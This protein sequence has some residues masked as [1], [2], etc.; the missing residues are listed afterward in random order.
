MDGNVLTQLAGVFA[1]LSL[2]SLG[3]GQSVIS[4][5]NHQVV[6]VHGWMTQQDFVDLFAISRAAPGPGSLLSTLIGWRIAGIGGVAAASLSYFIPSST[7]AYF[8]ART[9]NRY[10]GSAWQAA[11]ERGLAPVATGLIL[12]GAFSVL[13][14]SSGALSLLAITAVATAIFIL[15]PKLNPIPVLFAA[16]LVQVVVQIVS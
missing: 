5:I 15:R 9:W 12:S 8:A 10:K 1:P 6:E 13:Q 7:I 14:A 3:G 11:L 2:L 16:G 4:A